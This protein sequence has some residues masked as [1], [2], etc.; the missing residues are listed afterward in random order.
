MKIRNGFVSNSSSSSFMIKD[1]KE[2]VKELINNYHGVDYYEYKGILYTSFI[3]E[4]SDLYSKISKLSYDYIEG[5]DSPYNE[6]DYVEVEGE[7]GIDSVW[8]NREDLT[9][10]ELIKLGTVPYT[11]SC[12]LYLL[13]KNYFEGRSDFDKYTILEE[14]K[15]YIIYN[16][17]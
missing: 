8:L 16:E 13:L 7:L 4:C 10:E 3:S 14:C 1:N 15:N 12:Q 6:D 17:N 5:D 9:D 11:L 2:K